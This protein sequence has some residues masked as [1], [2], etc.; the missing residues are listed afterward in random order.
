MH[1]TIHHRSEYR[2]SQPQAR[3]VQLLH[4]TPRD[5]VGQSVVFWTVDIDCDA[6]LRHGRDGYGNITTMLYID[7]PVVR[8]GVTVRGDVVTEDRNGI[9]G[10]QTE[11]LPPLFYTR[12]TALT[13]PGEGVRAAAASVPGTRALELA[14]AMNRQVSSLIAIGPGRTR[15]APAEEVLARGTGSVRDAAHLLAAMAHARGLPARIVQGHAVLGETLLG[16]GDRQTAH[17]WTE[18]WIEAL[19]WVG[20]DPV[21]RASPAG[22]HVRVAAGRDGSE[23]APVAGTRRGGGVEELDVAVR[24]ATLEG[25]RGAEH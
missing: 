13:E 18:L 5:H 12:P 8:V 9:V 11:A 6:R 24:V 14:H 23:V 19:G 16:A 3:V 25:D 10:G 22:A 15:A 4:A 1:L 7:G 20:F 17:Y 2:F 21:T